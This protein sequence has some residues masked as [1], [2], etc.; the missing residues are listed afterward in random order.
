MEYLVSLFSSLLGDGVGA[1]WMF[2]TTL[3]VSA[4]LFAFAIILVVLFSID[5]VRRR[6]RSVAGGDKG[7][8][9]HTFA[10]AIE[11]LGVLVRPRREWERSRIRRELVEAGFRS[12]N[13]YPTFLAVKGLLMLLFP[14]LVLMG[15]TVYSNFTTFQV[16]AMV[17]AA[18][19]LGSL[20]PKMFLERRVLS[21]KRKI[22]N[23]FPDALDLL[24]ASSEAG[25]GLSAGLERVADE[26]YVSHPELADELTL[27][28]AE[29]R[30]GVERTDA[31]HN[32]AHRTG[33]EDIKGLVSLLSQSIRFG[34]SIS[35]ALRIYA[36]EFRDKRMQRAEEL[37]ATIG[38]KLI[39]P[40]I[41]CLFPAFFLVAIGPAILGVLRVLQAQ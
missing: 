25:L 33:I 19:F 10:N 9:Q 4:G 40:L 24:V 11:P 5:P 3:G 26:I 13:A 34:S 12:E 2:I 35:E 31:L 37:A 17:G 38:T 41:F 29:I 30:A 14:A 21:R 15:V 20:I 16:A 32:L 27:V 18:V 1:K 39:F 6:I 8:H 28:N 36:E 7:M 23:G 22:M